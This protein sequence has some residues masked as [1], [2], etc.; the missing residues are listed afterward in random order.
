MN[1]INKLF[2]L[3]GVLIFAACSSDDSTPATSDGTQTP[4]STDTPI[5]VVSLSAQVA[6]TSTKYEVTGIWK[7][8][9]YYNNV[10]NVYQR[11]VHEYKSTG[12]WT[13]SR[14]EYAVSD[15]NCSTGGTGVFTM[16]TSTSFDVGADKNMDGW[17]DRAGNPVTTLP[18]AIDGTTTLSSAPLVSSYIKV[19]NGTSYKDAMVIDDTVSY[20]P[21]M[22]RAYTDHSLDAGGYPTL[23]GNFDA[24]Y[25]KAS[26]PVKI[27]SASGKT[28]DITGVWITDCMLETGNYKRFEHTW[29]SDGRHKYSYHDYGA[30]DNTCSGTPSIL[31]FVWDVD[32]HVGANTTVSW[33]GTAPT[34]QDG[35]TMANTQTVSELVRFKDG[36]IG[37]GAVVL[38]DS[39]T[40]PV[41]YSVGPNYVS[42]TGTLTTVNEAKAYKK[43]P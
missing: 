33:V 20:A 38:D 36:T 34:A 17:V 4:A 35:S 14:E 11:D 21:V 28:V 42:Y 16:L 10:T 3:S 37:K 13:S 27:I 41:I 32:I 2:I 24:L 26:T 40:Q 15:T 23:A 7:S 9:C 43:L 30:S 22:Y 19:V 1:I 6:G 18:K 29:Y 39:T 5:S 8:A 31:K 12:S 25:R